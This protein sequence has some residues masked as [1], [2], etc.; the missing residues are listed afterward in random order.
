MVRWRLV[1]WWRGERKERT[2]WGWYCVVMINVKQI[3][4]FILTDEP[5]SCLQCRVIT[6][7]EFYRF[8][9]FLLESLG[10]KFPKLVSDCQ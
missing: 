5:Q 3:F 10:V 4:L 1:G 6:R 9:L 7:T 2:E 8:I